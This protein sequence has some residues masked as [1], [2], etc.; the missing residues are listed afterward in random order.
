MRRLLLALLG[1]FLLLGAAPEAVGTVAVTTTTIIENQ[2]ERVLQYSIAW[3]STAGGAVSAN[4]FRLNAPGRLLS[5]RYVP[6]SG[7]L[8]PSDQYD[9]TL[10][11]SDGVDVLAGGGAN[12][13]NAVA[14]LVHRDPPAYLTHTR[15]LDLVVANA[16]DANSGTVVLTVQN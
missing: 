5:V 13:S 9:V 10:V 1:L 12:L 16:G 3:T 7:G 6:G 15:T 8:Q 4:T 11:D 2:R 14:T